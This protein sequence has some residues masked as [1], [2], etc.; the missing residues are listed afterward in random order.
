MSER[1]AIRWL[2]KAR[3]GITHDDDRPSSPVV[4]V[5]FA[6]AIRVRGS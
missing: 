2:E 1:D 4:G 6:G 3:V 5:S